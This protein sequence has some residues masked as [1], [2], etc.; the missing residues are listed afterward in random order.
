MGLG[1]VRGTRT[2]GA[3]VW[4]PFRRLEPR[5]QVAGV[6]EFW[7]RGAVMGV[8]RNVGSG[9]QSASKY[10]VGLLESRR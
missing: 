10:D 9:A 3:Q 4:R 7:Q 1:R 8:G 5:R 2:D 6:G